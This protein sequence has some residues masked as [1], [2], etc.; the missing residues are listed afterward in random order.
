MNNRIYIYKQISARRR[1]IRQDLNYKFKNNVKLGS[2]R[3]EAR[4]EKA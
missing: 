2:A 1:R 4:Q 3:I